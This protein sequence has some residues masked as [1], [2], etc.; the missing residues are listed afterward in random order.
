MRQGNQSSGALAAAPVNGLQLSL[1]LPSGFGASGT[2]QE[3]SRRARRL[4]AGGDTACDPA[5][6][7]GLQVSL[8]QFQQNPYAGASADAVDSPTVA[9]DMASCNEPLTVENLTEPIELAISLKSQ[10]P[11]PIDATATATAT[12]AAT[13]TATATATAAAPAAAARIGT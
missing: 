4:S 3:I 1:A 7:G 6:A 2:C 10:P 8:A 11:E 5:G 13:A 12:A 9:V